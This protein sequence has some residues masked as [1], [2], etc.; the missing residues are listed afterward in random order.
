MKAPAIPATTETAA[1][2]LLDVR[3]LT[4]T[5]ASGS[6]TVVA[7]D[8]LSLSLAA[9]ETLG[10]VGESGSGKSVLCR[11]LMRLLP[12]PPAT[13]TAERLSLGGQDLM[14]LDERAMRQVRGRDIAMIF[15]NPM[16]SLNPVRR[17]GDQIGEPLRFHSGLSARASRS[18][19]LDLLHRVGIPSP[20]ARIDEY[21]YQW[22]GGMLQRASI[23]M[24]M[25]ASPKVLLADEP[26]TAL[27]VTIQDQILAL[28]L[29]LQGETGMALILVSHD[30]G[31]I[32]ETSDRLAVMYAG[33]I[34]ETGRT[35][36]VFHH[37]AHPYSR[38]LLDSIPRHD[39]Q[40]EHLLTIPGQPPDL[41][42][43]GPGCAFAPRCTLSTP[44][45]TSQPMVA[46]RID[47]RHETLCLHPE[48]LAAP[49]QEGI[50]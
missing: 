42:D 46:Q 40:V 38:G 28:L 41:G 20:H 29:D 15:Q 5:F 45:C 21:P 22:S 16:T 7:N 48:R 1:A 23:A 39:R 31:V 49:L 19:V 33:R 35:E 17:I 12:A 2:P 25:A 11:A 4:V 34:V 36:Q 44:D 8:S 18:R 26:T 50:A 9:G 13:I 6:R 3:G 30:M 14:G 24:A 43:L 47:P 32:G 10:I 27:D 37:P